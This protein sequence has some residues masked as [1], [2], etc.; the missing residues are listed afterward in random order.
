MYHSLVLGH[1]CLHIGIDLWAGS[2]ERP[3]R[4]TYCLLWRV[5]QH[6]KSRGLTGKAQP[7]VHLKG[8][9]AAAMSAERLVLESSSHRSIQA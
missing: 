3:T 5:F 8:A 4:S 7:A 9:W 6:R 2:R 1:Q